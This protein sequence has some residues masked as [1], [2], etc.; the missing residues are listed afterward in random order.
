[1]RRKNKIILLIGKTGSGRRDYI[2]KN[3]L[4][5][6]RPYTTKVR[7]M[8]FL[9]FSSESAFHTI[10][11]SEIVVNLI[12]N[13]KRY[14]ITKQC[15]KNKDVHI[16]KNYTELKQF[17]KVM[18][19]KSYNLIYIESPFWKRIIRMF[20]NGKNLKTILCTLKRERNIFQKVIKIDK[21]IKN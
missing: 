6:V 5:L 16:I 12:L 4:R 11:K 7:N 18:G 20:R 9:R 1:M 15:L 13:K 10:P 14:W 19:R 2:K 3:N 8:G 21:I 17:R